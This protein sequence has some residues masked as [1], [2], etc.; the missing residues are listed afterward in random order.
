MASPPLGIVLAPERDT[1]APR[2]A[3][4]AASCPLCG[5]GRS[6]Q[7]SAATDTM[8]GTVT[9]KPVMKLRRSHCIT[10]TPRRWRPG[11]PRR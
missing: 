2:E 10:A 5:A 8:S 1:A 7:T 4:P 9:K 11:A 6:A 3:E